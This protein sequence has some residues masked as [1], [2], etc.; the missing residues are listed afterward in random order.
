MGLNS[1]FSKQKADKITQKFFLTVHIL[2]CLLHIVSEAPEVI[3]HKEVSTSLFQNHPPITRISP[4][5]KTPHIPPYQQIGHPKFPF[6]TE[7]QP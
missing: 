7:M 2:F 6:L 3:V 1:I 4:F 5:L